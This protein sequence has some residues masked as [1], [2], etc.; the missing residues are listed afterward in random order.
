MLQGLM[1]KVEEEAK[2]EAVTYTKFEYW[3]KN[4][5][6]TLDSAIASSNQEIETLTAGI[7]GRLEEEEL[8]GDQIDAADKKA[9]DVRKDM[10]DLY[11]TT[12]TNFKSTIKAID[13]AIALLEKSFKETDNLLLAQQKVGELLVLVQPEATSEQLTVM[14]AFLRDGKNKTRP[15]LKAKG[16]Q[17]KHVKKYAFKSGSVIEILKQLSL[18]FQ[19]ERLA[20]TKA[21]TNS[22]NAYNLAK[23]ARDDAIKQAKA[24]KTEKTTLLGAAKA[25]RAKMESLRTSAKKDL[26]DD[27][28][29]L[30]RTKKACVV[31]ASE[32]SERSETRKLELEAMETAI[33]ILAKVGG[34]RTEAPSNPI[35]PPSPVKSASLLETSTD[36]KVKAMKLLRESAVA[37]HS[38]AL[39]RVAQEI[40]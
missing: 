20:A 38:R 28:D 9:K 7:N 36:P 16:D 19:D 17:A 32:W 1:A 39:E 15:V 2:D 22:V 13:E 23:N 37:T 27:S 34:V 4:S 40:S 11:T 18:K 6:K 10:A 21:E 26:S 5:E 30:E 3:C 24:S 8:L 31:K 29:T 14:Q 33:K 25:D 12:D 35:P